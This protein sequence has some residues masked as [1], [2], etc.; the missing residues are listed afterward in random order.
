MGIIGSRH[1][2]LPPLSH[3]SYVFASNSCKLNFERFPVTMEIVSVLSTH[4]CIDGCT[5]EYMKVRGHC[6]VSSSITLHLGS[7]PEPEVFSYDRWKGGCGEGEGERVI[8]TRVYRCMHIHGGQRTVES[9]I[10][11]TLH[12]ILLRWVLSLNLKLFFSAN[13]VA[14]KPQWSS[15]LWPQQCSYLYKW[16]TASLLCGF[17][18]LN[19][20]SDGRAASALNHL[21]VTLPAW[22]DL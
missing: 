4:V 15:S 5:Y 21:Q 8:C 19:W 17:W 18:D 13:L 2:I 20:G 3:S 11:A 10:S 22:T 7:L 9:V 16:D 14:I 12:L 1:Q 6:Q